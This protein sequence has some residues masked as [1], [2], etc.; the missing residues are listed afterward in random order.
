[1]G[2]WF[3]GNGMLELLPLKMRKA[4]IEVIEEEPETE[5]TGSEDDQACRVG[6]FIE[7]TQ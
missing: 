4:E 3:N 7:L 5:V 2:D 1:M 6:E